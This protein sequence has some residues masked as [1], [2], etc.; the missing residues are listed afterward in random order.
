MFATWALV[1]YEDR[2]LGEYAAVEVLDRGDSPLIWPC[3]NVSSRARRNT[4][5]NNC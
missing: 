4:R 2:V 5:S 3:K 1:A